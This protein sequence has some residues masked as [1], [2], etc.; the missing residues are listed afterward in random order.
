[1]PGSAKLV[2]TQ[3]VD[4]DDNDVRSNIQRRKLSVLLMRSYAESRAAPIED[5]KFYRLGAAPGMVRKQ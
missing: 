2:E 1:M 5:G 4:D 3:V